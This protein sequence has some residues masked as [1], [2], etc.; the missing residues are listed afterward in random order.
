MNM[1]NALYKN[2]QNNNEKMH[3]TQYNNNKLHKNTIYNQSIENCSGTYKS[4]SACMNFL[5]FNFFL[6]IAIKCKSTQ[7]L[8]IVI[9]YFYYVS[10]VVSEVL[11][12][13]YHHR[14]GPVYL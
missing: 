11:Y 2:R 14:Q 8:C 5:W 9:K 3:Q 1:K 7:I 6:Q 12:T 13:K 10:C 4:S